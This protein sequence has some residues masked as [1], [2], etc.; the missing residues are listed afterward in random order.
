MDGNGRL[1]P[2]AELAIRSWVNLAPGQELGISAYR[3]HAPLVRALA[4]AAY[5]AGARYVEA[6]YWDEHVRRAMIE[7]APEESL[8][9]SPPWLIDRIEHR[10]AE[11]AALIS[12]SGDPEPELLADL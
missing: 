10:A 8:T 2:Y 7:L 4:R 5:Q 6:S 3:E 1:E 12:I 9:W 11:Q